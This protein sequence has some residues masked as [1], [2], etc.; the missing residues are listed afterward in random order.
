MLVTAVSVMALSA[1]SRKQESP[2]VAVPVSFGAS[3]ESE[4]VKTVLGSD[5]HQVLWE[6]D[7]KIAVSGG[8]GA[9]EIKPVISG[10]EPTVNFSGEAAR[11]EVY[12]GAYPFSAWSEWDGS[13]ASMSLKQI[14]SA[15]A[16]SF[17]S[18]QNILVSSTTD[19][20]MD[21]QFRTVLGYLKFTVGEATGDITQV[22]VSSVGGEKLSG[23]FVVDCKS[24]APELVPGSG[25]RTYTSAAISSDRPLAQGDYYIAMFP[26]TYS[27]GLEF[28]VHG[29]DGVATKIVA[30]DASGNPLKLER[31][32]V[33]R[34]GTID[35]TKWTRSVQRTA[36]LTTMTFNVRS[37]NLEASGDAEYQL[38]DNRKGKI[39]AMINDVKPDLIGFQETVKTQAEDLRD[40]LTDYT[41]DGYVPADD[42]DGQ[43]DILNSIFYRK[44]AFM[45]L[46]S[47]SQYFTSDGSY[48]RMPSSWGGENNNLDISHRYFR[49]LKLAY[50]PSA[51]SGEDV[52]GNTV[53]KDWRTVWIFN[54]HLPVNKTLLGVNQDNTATR[55]ECIRVMIEK[56]KELCAEDDVIFLTGDLNASYDPEQSD[57]HGQVMTM[58]ET[59]LF[60]ARNET[61]D[62]DG[63]N[64]ISGWTDLLGY[65][66]GSIDHVFYRNVEP[67]KYRTIT[68]RYGSEGNLSD[69][70]PVS[71]VSRMTYQMPVVQ[72]FNLSFAEGFVDEALGDIFNDGDDYD[73]EN[74]EGFAVADSVRFLDN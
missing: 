45:M 39:A 38:W 9:F 31:G 5:G 73:K 20:E 3:F 24:V 33:N 44:D 50:L 65:G 46:E 15:R 1:C 54:T 72:A 17:T 26:G 4:E 32:K 6:P 49:W 70:F 74:V 55:K 41:W 47:G 29:P 27:K 37:M 62:R 40:A 53:Q 11:S 68:D 69:H 7:D 8:S 66:I 21:F 19:D 67:V 64:S 58:A 30:A 12:Y 60:S 36:E 25:E 63:Y 43:L 28:I 13:V 51:V 14:Q 56:I 2:V 48:G 16:G 59:W 57:T 42:T 35:V 71:F 18:E 34:L 23:E 61:A 22:I 52:A 10:A